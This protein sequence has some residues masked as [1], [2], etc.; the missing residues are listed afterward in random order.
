MLKNI[1]RISDLLPK[2]FWLFVDPSD[3]FRRRFTHV[4]AECGQNALCRDCERVRRNNVFLI[5]K[6]KNN[7]VVD[8]PFRCPPAGNSNHAGKTAA[9]DHLFPP[10]DWKSC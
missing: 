3:E 9:A 8:L 1:L 6:P 4:S 5:L 7:T 2:G 10:I